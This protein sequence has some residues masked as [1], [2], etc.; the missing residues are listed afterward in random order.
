MS[1]RVEARR[2]RTWEVDAHGDSEHSMR[3]IV[4][5]G[6]IKILGAWHI[7]LLLVL[8]LL[9][10]IGTLG[11][12]SYEIASGG[13]P[14]YGTGMDGELFAAA[15]MLAF[16]PTLAFLIFV[17]APLFAEDLRFNA[18][19]FYF[20]KPVSGR[21]YLWGKIGL[22]VLVLAATVLVPLLLFILMA[23]VGTILAKPPTQSFNW[24][25]TQEFNLRVQEW[26]LHNMDTFGDWAYA[27]GTVLPAFLVM[28]I[29]LI[30][31]FLTA[32]AWTS[33]AWHAAIAGLSVL[34][35]LSFLGGTVMDSSRTAMGSAFGPVGWVELLIF[36][37]LSRRFDNEPMYSWREEYYATYPAAVVTSYILMFGLIV[38][39]WF[40]M[41]LR[42]RRMEGLA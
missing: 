25:S 35:V 7:R 6:L 32:S 21:E 13:H 1:A 29:L 8:A 5:Y 10:T 37:P 18:P 20:S 39:C 4:K 26:H 12:F 40:A 3:T 27:V 33:R 28:F 42:I 31:I 11:A 17:A 23:L 19:L 15:V 41:Q 2:F 14:Q 16:L 9:F 22:L 36:I 24:E 38:A 34:G 30:V